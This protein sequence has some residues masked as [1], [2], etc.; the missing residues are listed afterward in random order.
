MIYTLTL[1]PSL[2]YMFSCQK[3][4]EGEINRG[5]N[6]SFYPGGKGINVSILLNRLGVKNTALGFSGGWTG[7]LI[8]NWLTKLDV[9][10]DF[11]KIDGES[12]VNVKVQGERIETA[13]N[14]DGPAV[15]ETDLEKL[16][17]KLDQL[18]FGDILI[19]GGSSG[20]VH[21]TIYNEIIT[22]YNKRGILCVLDASGKALVEG[23]KV[24]PFLIKPNLEELSEFT[25]RN[26]EPKEVPEIGKKIIEEYGVNYVLVSMGHLGACLVTP[27]EAIFDKFVNRKFKVVTTVGAGDCLLAGFIT[28]MSEGKPIKECLHFANFCGA[29]KCYFSHI[30][31]LNDIKKIQEN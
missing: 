1:A 26:V 15:M 13:F 30:P 10:H 18:D 31:T 16:Y 17:K 7:N 12:R 4:R 14:L 9:K 28:K 19:M 25:G 8:E 29:A 6:P 20:M 2:D 21:R 27:N 11:I 24:K 22:R 23:L 5:H 3:T